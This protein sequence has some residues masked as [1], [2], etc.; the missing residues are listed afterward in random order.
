MDMNEYQELAKRTSNKKLYEIDHIYNGVLGLAGE[1]GEC[2]DLVKKHFFQDNRP[3]TDELIDELGDV[4]WY[5]AE[6]ASAI[7]VSMNEIAV[8]NIVKL[9][10]RYPK[11]FEADRSLFRNEGQEE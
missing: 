5:I 2:C 11:G 1:A 10:K 6:T 9:K 4:L 7:G 8:A 3:I